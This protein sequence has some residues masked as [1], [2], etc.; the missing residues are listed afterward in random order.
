MDCSYDGWAGMMDRMA[1]GWMDSATDSWGDRQ[2][3]GVGG[4]TDGLVA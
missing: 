1:V 4:R 3:A 2:T